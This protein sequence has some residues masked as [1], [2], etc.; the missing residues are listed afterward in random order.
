MAISL[1][2]SPELADESFS[3]GTNQLFLLPRSPEQFWAEI[4]LSISILKHLKRQEQ[5][6][7]GPP[8]PQGP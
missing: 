7:S 1:S 8:C 3:Q 6:A 4:S 2:L 5:A